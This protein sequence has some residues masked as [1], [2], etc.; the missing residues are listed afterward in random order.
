[1]KVLEKGNESKGF[2]TEQ[3]CT[4]KGN[5]DGGCNARLLVGENDI[6]VTASDIYTLQTF[7]FTFKCPEC[8]TQTDIKPANL[9]EKVKKNAMNLY[10]A[11]QQK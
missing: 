6:F 4:G 1:M 10:K 5:G 8:K 11:K 2:E 3:I 7:Y 9:P